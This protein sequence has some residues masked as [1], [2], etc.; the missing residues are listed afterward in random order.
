MVSMMSSM[1]S[2]NGRP[3]DPAARISTPAMIAFCF[4]GSRLNI[5]RYMTLYCLKVIT[6]APIT[7]RP[8]FIRLPRL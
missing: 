5:S 6:V 4:A 3:P 8:M 2:A 7:L 1:S